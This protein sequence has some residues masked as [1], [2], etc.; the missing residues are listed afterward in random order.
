MGPP[1][2]AKLLHNEGNIH[3]VVISDRY[4]SS[5]M[6]FDFVMVPWHGFASGLSGKDPAQNP[7]HCAHE[8][9]QTAAGFGDSL[10]GLVWPAERREKGLG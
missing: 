7:R 3:G 10:P 4:T 1:E 6:T 2:L 8:A 5:Y 9:T